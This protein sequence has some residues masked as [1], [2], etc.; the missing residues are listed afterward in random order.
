MQTVQLYLNEGFEGGATTFIHHDDEKKNV[1]CIPRTG[2][3]L[4]FQHD[5]YH[6]GSALIKGRKYTI[7]TD[8]MYKP[9]NE[10]KSD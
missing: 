3:V 2:M 5:I 1:P 9:C 4:V 6:E 10:D 8:V 7:R